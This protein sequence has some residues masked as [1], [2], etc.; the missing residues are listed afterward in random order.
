MIGSRITSNPSARAP[1]AFASGAEPDAKTRP[2][3]HPDRHAPTLAPTLHVWRCRL[4]PADGRPHSILEAIAS[5]AELGN[6]WFPARKYRTPE[7]PDIRTTRLRC[8]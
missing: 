7:R 2:H 6:S 4:L 5:Q 1:G 3:F 8:W